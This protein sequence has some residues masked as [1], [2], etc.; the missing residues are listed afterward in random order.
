[1]FSQTNKP[2][3][4]KYVQR[5]PSKTATKGIPKRTMKSELAGFEPLKRQFTIDLS[6]Q[7][8]KCKKFLRKKLAQRRWASTARKFRYSSLKIQTSLRTTLRKTKQ[9]KLQMIKIRSNRTSQV[10]KLQHNFTFFQPLFL[11]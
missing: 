4:E 11:V 7:C 2:P 9:V 5:F 3:L 8:L 6:L 1:M 10:F